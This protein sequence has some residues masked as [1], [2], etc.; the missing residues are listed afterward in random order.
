MTSCAPKVKNGYSKERGFE[1]NISLSGAFALYPL[2]VIWSEDF[3]KEHPHVRFNISAG[4]AGKGIADVL[5]GMVDIGLVSRDLH[6]QEIK[7]G[8]VPI[9]VAKDAVI[10]T[11]NPGNPNYKALL[12]RGLTRDELADIFINRKF[13]TWKEI[14]P[15]F[16]AD[17][18]NVYVRSDAAGAAETWAKFFDHKQEDLQGVGIFGDPGIAQAIKDDIYGIGFNNI[19]YVYNLKTDKVFDRIDVLPLDLNNSGQ[20]DVEEQ[21][22]HSLSQLTEAVATGKYPAPPARD[23]TFVT[24]NKTESL[25][26]KEFIAF[27]LKKEAQS[28]LLQN[29]YVPLNETLIKQELNKL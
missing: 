4:G 16:T 25:L 23:L 17:P 6:P 24:H 19:N 5:T 28:Q 21:F 9:I 15:R 20:L 8:A 18:I 7:K 1:G 10:C 14:D 26:L 11:I 12:Q 13:R 3:K 22:Y 29:G 2:V 27:V